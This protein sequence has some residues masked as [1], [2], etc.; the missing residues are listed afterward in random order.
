MSEKNSD[1]FE[2]DEIIKSIMGHNFTRNSRPRSQLFP[3]TPE[4]HAKTNIN[5]LKASKKTSPI[6]SPKPRTTRNSVVALRTPEEINTLT[7]KTSQQIIKSV[8]TLVSSKLPIS[9]CESSELSQKD[10]EEIQHFFM[11]KKAQFKKT[12]QEISEKNLKTTKK[13]YHSSLKNIKALEK[14]YIEEIKRMQ[15][16]QKYM[17]K[18]LVKKTSERILKEKTLIKKTK[19]LDLKKKVKETK[20]IQNYEKE[21]IIKNIDNFYKDKISLI[22]DY[23]QSEQERQ[24]VLSY[25]EKVLIS[26][27]L[28]H[29]K[30]DRMQKFSTL[31]QKYEFEIEQLKE[32]FNSIH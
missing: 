3:K 12:L 30:E 15:N 27:F 18:E 10:Q 32:K 13:L 4:I 26:E 25:E 6:F 7:K 28:K 1:S 16:K 31:K 23:C 11:T 19:V 24:K 29:E 17:K 14:K 9:L 5:S 21:L 22:K 20:K 2:E 8:Y